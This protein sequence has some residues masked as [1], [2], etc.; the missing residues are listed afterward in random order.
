[1]KVQ[2]TFQAQKSPLWTWTSVLSLFVLFLFS[3]SSVSAQSKLLG[4]TV[5]DATGAPVEGVNVL[6][7]SSGN[8]V[9]T[10]KNGKYSINVSP[11]NVLVFSST[12][13][14]TQELSVDDRATI[15]V[16]LAN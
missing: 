13:F 5:T 15:N 1:M 16:V 9:T 6:V 3:F 7:K 4:G 10:D 11:G 12:G 8:G 2:K 14:V